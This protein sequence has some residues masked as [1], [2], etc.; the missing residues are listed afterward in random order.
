MMMY[1]FWLNWFIY[2]YCRPCG[3]IEWSLVVQSMPNVAL[4][5][6]IFDI[7]SWLPWMVI[8]MP[9]DHQS[10]ILSLYLSRQIPLCA[11][12]AKIRSRYCL[13]LLHVWN[14]GWWMV[15]IRTSISKIRI[16]RRPLG[17]YSKLRSLFPISLRKTTA[18]CSPQ[19]TSRWP[20]VRQAQTYVTPSDMRSGAR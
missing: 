1:G 20:N 5:L 3:L 19:R 17:N 11:T 10:T 9:D 13:P 16:N 18:S 15:W 7:Y 6:I 12:T 8:S 4:V 14:K 2:C